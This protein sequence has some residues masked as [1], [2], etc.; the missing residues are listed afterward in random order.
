MPSESSPVGPDAVRKVAALARLRVPEA[1]L[2]AWTDRLGR[3]LSHIGQLADVPVRASG[4]E[5]PLLATPLRGDEPVSGEGK[6][7]LEENSAS[8]VHGYGGV[9]R[10]V[11]GSS[12]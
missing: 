7:A 1:E 4:A 3:I 12:S 11:G 6:R 8:V 10:V 2:A 9:P 5:V